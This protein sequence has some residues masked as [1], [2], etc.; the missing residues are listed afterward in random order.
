MIRFTL[1]LFAAALLNASEISVERAFNRL[2]SFQFEESL[3]TARAYSAKNASDPMGYASLSAAYLFSE[4]NR[5]QV[6]SKDMFKEEKV[7]GERAKQIGAEAKR[8][9]EDALNRAK[10]TGAEALKKNDKDTNALLA[11][12]IATGA[13]RDFSALVEK[14]YKDSYYAAKASQEYALRLQAI[15]PSLHDAWF[16]RGFSEYLIG[17]VPFVV[18]W[19]MKIE[20]ASGDKK[21]GL[22]LMEKCARDGKYLKPFAQMM[23][24]SIY[25]KDKRL[26]ES[27]SLLEAFA[28]DHPDNQVVR[29]ELAKMPKS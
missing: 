8:N 9:F 5:L 11:L 25:Q 12:L 21:K 19:L 24:A 16:T 27:R 23:L 20:Q 15:D 3:S 6:F 2:Y 18:R 4:M 1:S 13:E 29:T 17:S 28:A 26:K 10:S 22:E 7:K 14:R